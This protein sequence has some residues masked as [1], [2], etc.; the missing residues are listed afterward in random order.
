MGSLA[1]DERSVVRATLGDGEQ[2]L[3]TVRAW[4]G[5]TRLVWVLTDHRVLVASAEP[6]ELVAIQLS[7]ISRLDLQPAGIGSALWLYADDQLYGLHLA[8]DDEAECFVAAFEQ[9]QADAMV[10]RIVH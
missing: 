5:E 6:G 8:N 2:V 7:C 4:D 1:H 3:A 10:L 9:R